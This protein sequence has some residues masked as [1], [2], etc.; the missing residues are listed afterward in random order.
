MKHEHTTMM[1]D[2]VQ[3]AHFVFSDSTENMMLM[4]EGCMPSDPAMV[5]LFVLAYIRGL[6][7][8][9]LKTIILMEAT[10]PW[11][12]KKEQAG[13]GSFVDDIADTLSFKNQ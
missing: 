7:E 5:V 8:H 1:I 10:S 13:M 9:A 4:G 3:C 2:R 6:E 11:T 12:G